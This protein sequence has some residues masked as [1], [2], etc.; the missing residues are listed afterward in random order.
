LAQNQQAMFCV[1]S[2]GEE[3]R[4]TVLLSNITYNRARYIA[5][6]MANF[7]NVGF[8]GCEPTTF[9]FPLPRWLR[10]RRTG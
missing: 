3:G 6:Q 5:R 10:G 2:N 4:Q 7:L 8:I 1:C 9:A